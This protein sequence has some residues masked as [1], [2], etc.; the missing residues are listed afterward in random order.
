MSP[1]ENALRGQYLAAKRRMERAQVMLDGSRE[2]MNILAAMID[3]LRSK[4]LERT[5]EGEKEA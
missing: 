5:P 4:Q 2:S 1:E 3:E